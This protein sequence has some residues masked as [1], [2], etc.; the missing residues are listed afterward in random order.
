[1]AQLGKEFVGSISEAT[2]R[3]QDLLPRF[4]SVLEAAEPEHELV[5][6]W[7]S[8]WGAV[9]TLADAFSADSIDSYA[10]SIGFW[11]E[12]H[13]S[14]MLNEE[15]FD[16]LNDVAPEGTYFSSSEGDGASYGF[17]W[18]DCDACGLSLGEHSPEGQGCDDPDYGEDALIEVVS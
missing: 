3:V 8:L 11:D 10:E 1:M 4:I 14:Y 16:A 6:E 2:M 13:L 12:E 15:V 18:M 5:G 17:W 7:R 9:S